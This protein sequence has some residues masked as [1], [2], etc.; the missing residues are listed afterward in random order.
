MIVEYRVLGNDSAAQADADM[1][2]GMAE[3]WPRR[4][5]TVRGVA[6]AARAEA[7]A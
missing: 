4:L 5:R 3:V 6:A 7:A 1:A 2:D